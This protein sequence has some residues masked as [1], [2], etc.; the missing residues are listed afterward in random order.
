MAYLVAFPWMRFKSFSPKLNAMLEPTKI[1]S[2][3]RRAAMLCRLREW[4]G[5]SSRSD[6]GS[7]FFRS[8]ARLMARSWR[9]R[10]SLALRQRRTALRTAGWTSGPSPAPAGPSIASVFDMMQMSRL[11]DRINCS[12][13]GN[14]EVEV[15]PC[16][17][18]SPL[19]QTDLGTLARVHLR[20]ASRGTAW[21]CSISISSLWSIPTYR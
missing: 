13:C 16:R 20:H 8:G 2:D 6:G 21:F 9:R 3:A 11:K 19:P 4:E 7:L 10:Y 12:W 18:G 14:E 5:G 1:R 17:R 15:G